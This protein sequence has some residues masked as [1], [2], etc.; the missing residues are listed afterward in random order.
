MTALFLDYAFVNDDYFVGVADRGKPVRDDEHRADIH[1]L[2]ERILNENLRFGVDISRRFVQNHNF[3]AMNYRSRERKQLPLSRG[4]VVAPFADFLVEFRREFIDEF[5]S[6]DVT[7]SLV[8]LLVRERF[9]AEN[10]VAPYRSGEQEN[11]LQHLPRNAY[12]KRI[13]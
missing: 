6:V 7:A 13:F 5:I 9:F 11:V 2:F 12:A 3:R 8:D 1:H 10:Y 4:E